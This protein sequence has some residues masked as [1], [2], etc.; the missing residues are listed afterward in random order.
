MCGSAGDVITGGSGRDTI[1]AGSAGDT[2][3]A[4]DGASV[5]TGG[6]GPDLLV[7]GI[8]ADTITAGSGNAT[9]YAAQM[10]GNAIQAGSGTDIIYGSGGAGSPGHGDTIMGGSGQSTIHGSAGDDSIIGGT[11]A[12]EIDVGAGD[13]TVVGGA[14]ALLIIGGIGMDLLE[15]GA[16]LA[17]DTIKGGR[18]NDTITGNAG[19]DA[20]Y[21]GYGVDSIAGGSGASVI[22]GGYGI[23]KTI[24]GGSGDVTIY[25]SDTGQDVITGG[26]GNDEIHGY[27]GS[28]TISG[29][30]GND[31]IE[32]GPGDDSIMGGSG[33]DLLAGDAGNDTIVAGD[34]SSIGADTIYGDFA[35]LQTGVAGDDQLFG[36]A[37]ND[38][39]FGGLGSD[40]ISPGT[41]SG[42]VVSEGGTA[43]G[44]GFA[45]PA[46]PNPAPVNPL[47]VPV[48]AAAATL[49]A[50]LQTAGIW[51]SL[52]GDP[53]SSLAQ[54]G[55][56]DM[57]T[58]IAVSGT[59]RYVAW[60][61]DR[62]GADAVYVAAESGSAWSE[63]AGS[64]EQGGVSGL[65]ET[66]ADPS[67]ALL[68]NGTPIVAWT[69]ETQTGTD[70][71]LAEYSASANAWVALGTSLSAGGLSGTGHAANAQLVM[72]GGTPVVAWLDT[73]SGV[74]NVYAK[75]FNGTG[76]VA[77][78]A[79]SGAGI[80]G[81]A[82]AIPS[83]SLATDGTNVALAWTQPIGAGSQIYVEQESGGTFA[84]L[85]GSASGGG[86]SNALYPAVAPTV[87]YN[88][89][90]LFVAWQQYITDPD[91]ADPV[92]DSAPSI[93][94][95]QYSGGA[96][97]AAGAGADTGFGVSANA[98]INTHPVLASDN[99]TLV[100]GWSN[101]SITDTTATTHL[102]I[103]QW[104]G[105]AFVEEL[106]GQATGDGVASGQSP[107][108]DLALAVD[109]NGNAFA[110]WIDRGTAAPGLHVAGTPA[111]PN[112]LMVADATHSVQSLLATAV[113][114]D[115]IYVTNAAV[116]GALTL[117]A[118]NAGVTLVGQTGGGAVI[119]GLLTVT[120]NGITI[121][122]LTLAA[123]ATLSGTGD[124]LEM[125]T[126]S[127]GALN[128]GGS[129]ARVFN[130]RIYG[131]GI[132]LTAATGFEIRG[133]TIAGS[134]VGIMLGAANTGTIDGNI[135]SGGSMGLDVA[136][137][138]TGPIS[139]NMITASSI[140]VEYDAAAALIG[141]TI[142]NN[143]TGVS[144]SVDNTSGGFGFAPG[145]GQNIVTG[146]T[147]GVL[148]NNASIQDQ[149]IENNV[150]GVT[151]SGVIGG[152]ALSLANDITGNVTGVSGFS[153]TIQFSE[154]EG[155]GTGIVATANLHVFN[156]VV[157][158][159]TAV[160]LLVSGV[161]G[162]RVSDTTFYTATGD[163]VRLD[164][165]A[166]DFEIQNSILWSETGYD[167]YVANDSQTGF[168]SDYNVLYAG[169]T[170]TL[171]YWTRNFTDI[172]DWQDDVALYDLH[173]TGRTVVNPE[174]GKPHFTDLA[175]N[176][177]SI[178]DTVGGQRLSSP[179]VDQGSTLVEHDVQI[180]NGN[181][182]T[183]PGF[184]NGLVGWT[185][186]PTAQTA[187]A[188][189]NPAPYDGTQYFSAG[190]TAS[191][192]VMQ[193]VNLLQE[194]YSATQ[195]DAGGFVVDF[196]GYTRSYAASPADQG[197]IT[198]LF[199]DADNDLLGS[200]TIHALNTSDRWSLT[201]G[202]V[203]LAAGTRFITF[204]FTALRETGNNDDAFLDDAYVSLVP[205]S[206]AP[207][208]ALPNVAANDLAN[209]GF[210][211]GLGS[212]STNAGATVGSA[213]SGTG[214][215]AA[216]DGS[217]YFAAGSTQ[218]GF[219]QQT[220][221][222]LASGL[223]AAA[224]DAGALDLVY[225]GRV[226]S[227][228][229]SPAD[230]GQIT[231]TFLAADGTT[232]LGTATANAP[233]V[234]DRWALVGGQ[235]QIPVGA[236]FVVYRF[237]ATRESGSTDDAFLD[238]AFVSTVAHGADTAAGAYPTPDPT[239]ESGGPQLA[240]TYPDLYTDWEDTVP[241]TITW[242]SFGDATNSSVQ[243]ELLQDT[244]DGPKLLTT[245]ASA[246][247]DTGSYVWIPANTGIG[248][249]TYG[250]RIQISLVND[251]GVFDR[252]AEAFTV[253]ENGNTYYVNDGSTVGDQYTTATG[254]NRNDGKLP[255]AP[256]PDA[257][258]VLR[259]YTLG[260]GSTI[261]V[262]AGTYALIDPVDVSGNAA[263]P[264]G[265]DQGFVLTGPT[266][267]STATFETAIPDNTSVNLIQLSDA[268]FVTVENLTLTGAGR[269]IF[270][271]SS[272]NFT[273]I[274]LTVTDIADEG[275]RITN[276][277]AAGLLDNVTVTGAGLSGIYITGGFG[278]LED[279]TATGD[280]AAGNDPTTTDGLY[281]SGSITSIAGGTFADNAG[282]GLYL[283]NAGA[284]TVTGLTVDDN[285]YGIH[286]DSTSAAEAVVGALNLAL[287]DG[288]IVFGN[289][290]AGIYANG[291][292]LVAGNTVYDQ[293]G[294][295]DYGIYAYSG[296]S[297]QENVVYASQ[298]GIEG[299]YAGTLAANLVYGNV[300]GIDDGGSS[301]AVSDNVA[302]GNATG[303][304]ID[305]Y[306]TTNTPVTNN[307]VY[308][309]TIVGI[310]V[311]GSPAVSIVSDTV[312]AQQGI[313]VEIENTN[314]NSVLRDDIIVAGGTAS[315][316][317]VAPDSETGFQSDYNLFQ[318][319]QTASVGTWQ[320]VLR[321]T[322]PL[323]E[324]A[325]TTDADSFVANPLFVSASA[326]DLAD[327]DFHLQSQYGSTHGASLAPVISLT[328]GLP[329]FPVSTTVDDRATSPGIDRG[330][331][332][333]SYANEPSPNGGYLNL[334]AYGN[335]PQASISP[336]QYILVLQPSATTTVQVGTSDTI[337]WRAY[338]FTGTVSL[339]ISADG[340]NTFTPIVSGIADSGSYVWS[341]PAGLTPGTAYVI[342][343]SADSAAVSG[344][345]AEFAI[346]SRIH[347][348]YVDDNALTG[349]QYTTAVGNDANDGL[350]PATPK[351]T[352][353]GILAAYV[354][355]AGDIVYVDTGTYAVTTSITLTSAVSGTDTNDR[356]QIIGPTT[357]GDTA[358]LDRGNQSSGT[359]VFTVTNA[360]YV[361]IDNLVIQDAAH[362]IEVTGPAVG[363]QLLNDTIAGTTTNALSIDQG[364]GATG[365]D[366]EAGYVY[367]SSSGDGIYIG[368]GNT[369]ALIANETASGGYY[370]FDIQGTGDTVQGGSATGGLYGGLQ[371]LSNTSLVEGFTAY[372]NSH[373]GIY[374]QG[375]VTGSVAFENSSGG[376]SA[377][378][379][380]VMGS[381]AYGQPTGIVLANGSIGSG[382]LVYLDT[383]GLYVS[384]VS[385]ATDNRA[386]DNSDAGIDLGDALNSQN[387]V[388]DNS[389]Y[390]NGTGIDGNSYDGFGNASG[391]LIE[392]NVIYEN[393]V[394]GIG[395]TNGNGI[396]VINNT[397][398]QVGGPGFISYG[399]AV[400]TTVENNI[401]VATGGPAVSVNSTSEVGFVSDYNLFDTGATG[402][403][404]VW[405]GLT[406]TSLASWYYEVGLDQNS[407]V[408]DPGFINPAGADGILGF[409]TSASA[410]Q[411]AAATLVGNWITQYESGSTTAVAAMVAPPGTGAY[412]T[413]SFSGLVVGAVYQLQIDWMT[414]ATGYNFGNVTYTATD[415][416]GVVLATTTQ[417]NYQYNGYLDSP[418]HYYAV[419]SF[420]ATTASMTLTLAPSTQ[421]ALI[422]GTAMLQAMGV[423]HG[424]DDDFHLAAG[425]I[426]VDEGNPVTV[427]LAEPAPNGGRVNQ[428]SDGGSATAN[429]SPSD[430]EVQVLSPA[431]LAKLQVGQQAV[432]DFRTYDIAAQ[433]PVL[434]DHAGGAAIT[435][436]EQG[437]WQHDAY[438]L[439][440]NTYTDY[441]T[442]TGVPASLPASLFQTGVA[443]NSGTGNELSFQLP[444]A[445]G[446]YTL[447]LFFADPTA[448]GAGQRVFDVVGN[449]TTLVSG[450]DVFAATG[451][452]NQAYELDVTVTV[453]GGHGLSLN[454][455]NDG[456]NLP[457]FVD[458]I[459]LDH[460]VPGGA[461]APTANIQVSTDDGATWS[462]I[463]TNVAVNRFGL[464]Q[465]VWTVD[466]TTVGNT[467]LIRVTSG[468]TSGV[469]G[470]FLLANNGTSFYV[471]DGSQAGD[472][473][474][475]AVGNDANSGK[476]P[477]QPLASLGALLRAYS[478]GPG[479]TVYVDTGNY[480]LA[481]DLSLGTADSG[482]GTTAAT[483]VLITGPTNGGVAILN[484]ANTASGTAVF[485]ITAG[486]VTI[487]NL[488]LENASEVV[489]VTA[490]AGLTLLNDTVQ[491]SANVG[492]LLEGSDNITNFTLSGSTLRNNTH[493]GLSIGSGN[494]G[495]VIS[496]DLAYD[497]GYSGINVSGAAETLS[498][499][500]SYGNGIV[501]RYDGIDAYGTDSV[502]LDSLAYGNIGEGIYSRGTIE[503]STAF[504]N[505]TDEFQADGGTIIGSTAHDE[506]SVYGSSAAITLTNA[507]VAIDDTAYL[508]VDGFYV[509]PGSSVTDSRAYANSDDGIDIS[510]YGAPNVVTGDTIY[511]NTTGIG[512]DLRNYGY[513]A[514]ISSAAT[515]ENDLIYGNSTVGIGFNSGTGVVIDNNTFD[516][517]GAPAIAVVGYA[518]NEAIENN[519]FVESGSP[520]ITVDATSE[521]G[522]GSDY[523]VFDLSGGATIGTFAGINYATLAAW[524][525]EIGEDQHSQL[526]DPDL[527]NP[528][529]ADGVLGYTPAVGATSVVVDNSD[530]AFA[531]HGPTTTISG[532]VSGSA[533]VIA[534]GSSTTATWT[535]TGLVLGESYQLAATW[536]G[537][538]QSYGY[539]TYVVTNPQGQ[540]IAANTLGQGN[541]P[542]NTSFALPNNYAQIDNFTATSSTVTVTLTGTPSGPVI[543]NAVSL[544]ALGFDH[545]A[546]DNF[547]LAAGSI[548]VDAGDPRIRGTPGAGAER[549]ARQPGLPGRHGGGKHQSGPGG[550]GALAGG[551]GQAAGRPAG[552]DRLPHLRHRRRA[553]RAAG[554]CRR[555]C[556][557]DGGTGRLAGRRLPPE[558]HH[559]HQLRHRDGCASVAARRAVPDR[560][561]REFRRRQCREL[562]VAR[563]GRHL[564][565][566]AVLRRSVGLRR[567]AACV[568][569]GRQRR[570]PGFGRRRVR[571]DRCAE[572]GLR[573]GHHRHG[574]RRQRAGA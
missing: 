223:S 14:G 358:T 27:G 347:A 34:P 333:D 444:V 319:S 54:P 82:V 366:I 312:D 144:A 216:F 66:A 488:L 292:V 251:P 15:A 546:D 147:V 206:A 149:L 544:T 535:F 471:N 301:S 200:S 17:R 9:I 184:E 306:Y 443:A 268:N 185:A 336:S 289:T 35:T 438:R 64:A 484:R 180:A 209:P 525:Y 521:S 270:V 140:G 150:T 87:A 43:V 476:S 541:S 153:G 515:I 431:G 508:S 29:G 512:G 189:G 261:D 273:G 351:A 7:G 460:V 345:S 307:L 374:T 330:A 285:R 37:G 203:A 77:L 128:V 36:N 574:D 454:L 510:G 237:Q 49:P 247:A 46:T 370:G 402:S 504:G 198:V 382:N 417:P 555:R 393:T 564:H 375:T 549:R 52:A 111:A 175:A 211:T 181:L 254:S 110:S 137:A 411:T 258:N 399:G 321:A 447:R 550:A 260:A 481:T 314:S 25:G 145:S 74:A 380:T 101:A 157:A 543:A 322:L 373:Y 202:S 434:L 459:E 276:N 540:V 146:N 323:W 430:P 379:G 256:K 281:V 489:D 95:A 398:D 432:I 73:S 407:Q 522:I 283:T 567:R 526:G 548:A 326:A 376:I 190:A 139:G 335:T 304:E 458:G 496:N 339:S 55:S 435:T 62:S 67:I 389:I 317:V 313:G 63:L 210:E 566:A 161:S 414:E 45:A 293:T 300:R 415:G 134:R 571:G 259:V 164:N 364:A 57:G 112:H 462:T 272:S 523:N 91:I 290:A 552:D 570:D 195:I 233:N 532:G 131:A 221:D 288:N 5:I 41:G 342:Q 179:S 212:W 16:L 220:V 501:Y 424:G 439:N 385:T 503:D 248:Y 44:A 353:Q 542:S 85:A 8:A 242:D 246:V 56:T 453:T 328:T 197:T 213:G 287:G 282:Y 59:T 215:P 349:N 264:L 291:D 327:D 473:Y 257:V 392:G 90:S 31:T 60:V 75:E 4:G 412:A 378:G 561:V 88:S 350:T 406:Y 155:N 266:N 337:T 391:E 573:T 533:L 33:N 294:A 377:S 18:G 445:D 245:I 243:I 491:G 217:G 296:A 51:V 165:G 239:P 166:S 142:S 234:S 425:S 79:A 186:D 331:A 441:T 413:W 83:F 492:V 495:A 284:V 94:A 357:A 274:N 421:Y 129:G 400:N 229:E 236:R 93:Y 194:G 369:G 381:T 106:P 208:S 158:R 122:G 519:I 498:G 80:T 171:V 183:N 143:A 196:G 338:G 449:G 193:T 86:L 344:L 560:R 332:S 480:T 436:Q 188:S 478:L 513:S 507:A 96:W 482:S 99:G 557:H 230:Q 568:R 493:E 47:S 409:Q 355:G 318:V 40:Y 278:T 151:G 205:N 485:H 89:G 201:S 372:A 360:A 222:L 159:N 520:A 325:T 450:V 192:F 127:G 362:G 316:I 404:G 388:S 420:V 117:G 569:R 2:V 518:N 401:F 100:L 231:V 224:I 154:I 232:Q 506:R 490:G 341:V 390:G 452:Q 463:A 497:N 160:G 363:L 466:R 352:I 103:R 487:A 275:I 308:G 383:D 6:A 167:I 465:F 182:L 267:G 104:N 529:G 477:D 310:L 472:Q 138:F 81:S 524:Y 204:Q 329:V 178:Q 28:N 429:A 24:F 48:A 277:V 311:S 433:Q 42:T 334:G 494:T 116:T 553:A 61:D 92:Y 320:G 225:G 218:L 228:N 191:G 359:T 26:S 240:L 97:S 280:G 124:T 50:N 32:G 114:G 241:H 84:P 71:Q 455:V 68:P 271:D 302:Y 509:G 109:S 299:Q 464:G 227:G 368:S 238:D 547:T 554:P 163:N 132:T 356:F 295:N 107:L 534:Q 558:R 21:G 176:D 136:N 371:A 440:G 528:A 30:T 118:A 456:N 559:L 22:Y 537:S 354:L 98:S 53:G 70:I 263:T 172:L 475:T 121:Q 177:F 451:V 396:A 214:Y 72:V 410:P 511:G 10:G 23:G 348:Y 130:S 551:A 226:R 315:G 538:Y 367:G 250:L 120:G 324:A 119:G 125:A 467:A 346:S 252:S 113:S 269:G 428:G 448:S 423:D 303:I 343:V 11:G 253:P 148:L 141:N 39:I 78:G 19:A 461:A 174:G 361:S 468:A 457:A 395:L 207:Q 565:A 405:E 309:N 442:V 108:E 422:S 403:I 470:A 265:L 286:I 437:D 244:P 255:S 499:D 527:V 386:Y 427:A 426:A 298:D 562:P 340:G 486:D 235:V 530:P 126:M 219:A 516:Q 13:A 365:L 76:W 536:P 115:V 152:A 502:V 156:N 539:A 65:V 69:V 418:P 563:G 545:S 199:F 505:G 38:M 105:S 531:V 416:N 514:I 3:Y 483:Q 446:T 474:T 170:G 133:N 262:D 279:I 1:M 394:A 162:V 419:G 20:L 408:G 469:S 397:I 556:D 500:T 135:I 12:G 572:P 517:A 169:N 249:G 168:F 187:V 479:D 387:V 58:S 173:S 123:G 384:G 297:A 305:T 102:Y